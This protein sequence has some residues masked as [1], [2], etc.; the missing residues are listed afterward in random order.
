MSSSRFTK[1]ATLQ[2]YGDVYYESFQDYYTRIWS[3][4]PDIRNDLAEINDLCYHRCF[5]CFWFDSKEDYT[6]RQVLLYNYMRPAYQDQNANSIINKWKYRL[7]TD[8]Y[9]KDLIQD[10]CTAYDEAPVR[11]FSQDKNT[12]KLMQDIF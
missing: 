3:G 11:K 7:P 9:I 1:Y 12:E 5:S 10:V 6:D 2:D 8:N 4:L